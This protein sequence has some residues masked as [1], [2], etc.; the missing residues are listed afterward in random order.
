VDATLGLKTYAEAVNRR[1]DE[2]LP[3]EN[4]VPAALHQAMR[5]S[6][7][8]P[9]KRLRPALV[10]E[11]ARAVGGDPLGALDAACAIEF[12]HAFSLIHD[13]LPALD[14]DELRRGRP[15]CH[16]QF[17][18]ATAILAGDGLFALAFHVIGA[19]AHVPEPKSEA[20]V[21]LSRASLRLVQGEALDLL[22]EGEIGSAENVEFIHRNKTGALI[23]CACAIGGLL[24]GG[25]PAEVD[26]LDRYGE[27]VGLA[28][29]I[30]DDILNETASAEALG[31]AA[32]SDQERGKQTYPAVFGIERSRAMAQELIA[33][34][35]DCLLELSGPIDVLREF[36]RYSVL[37]SH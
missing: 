12:V 20:M 22:S 3:P 27:M 2:L 7:L 9:G 31:K 34:A 29:Q 11:S 6:A 23:S 33:S 15:T 16:V 8:A 37:R 4:A 25:S 13:D 24:G 21:R 14:D 18:E 10:M 17:G 30:A 1:M 26:A 36:A 28:F 19:G 32:G 35:E 5:Y